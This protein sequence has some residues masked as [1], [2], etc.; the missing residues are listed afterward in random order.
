MSIA[1]QNPTETFNEFPANARQHL[2]SFYAARMVP[3]DDVNGKIRL[4]RESYEL[5]GAVIAADGGIDSEAMEL[6][7]LEFYV[8]I[9][10]G[11][12]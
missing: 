6:R 10:L 8:L 2:D 7:A 12:I 9:K 4:L 1:T 5:E 11:F 3:A